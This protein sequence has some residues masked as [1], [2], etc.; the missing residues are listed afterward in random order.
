MSIM[1]S[2][3]YVLDEK[4]VNSLNSYSENLF[5]A[6]NFSNNSVKNHDWA[7]GIYLPISLFS[8]SFLSSLETIVKYVKEEAGL[9]YKE[10]SLILNRDER[11]IWGTY[12]NAKKKMAGKF[13]LN[14]ITLFVPLIIFSYRSLSVLE[15]ITAYLRDNYNLRYCQIAGFLTRDDRT[16][17]TIYSRCLKKNA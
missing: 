6:F 16:I 5:R 12:H 9:S 1:I 8:N 11:T 4:K 17:W 7:K 3:N 2:Q 15:T 13:K 10:I 14:D